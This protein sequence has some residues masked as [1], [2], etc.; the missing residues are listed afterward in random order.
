MADTTA[1]PRTASPPDDAPRII[2]RRSARR[3][4]TLAARREGDAILVMVPDGM[5]PEIESRQVHALVARLLKREE[6]SSRP[7]DPGELERRAADLALR[8]LDPV[9]GSRVRPSS[10][11][12]V[13]NQH[14][15]WGSC[16]PSTGRIRLSDTM[17]DFPAWVVDHVLLHE[18]AHLVEPNHGARFKSLAKSHPRALE[19]EGF[20]IGWSWANRRDHADDGAAGGLEDDVDQG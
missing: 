18:L 10:V 16:T 8:Y 12:W 13:S 17:Q 1:S 7:S 15:R 14:H 3:R 19:A 9:V 5:D 2:V 11:L 4:R 6:I 20:L